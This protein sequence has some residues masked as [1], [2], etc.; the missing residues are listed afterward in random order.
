M[1]HASLLFA[2]LKENREATMRAARECL[3]MSVA[4][5]LSQ[6]V[7][8]EEDM[9]QMHDGFLALVQEALEERPPETRTLYLDVVLPSLLASGNSVE[10]LAFTA[11]AW[12]I[13][14][15]DIVGPKLPAEA[16]DEC[17]KWI[18]SFFAKLVVDI[19]RVRPAPRSVP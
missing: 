10:A 1:Q 17:V 2:V 4:A 19:S 11:I 15:T 14:L 12:S 3:P 8:G 5:G 16:H 7:Y 6:P 18:S 9:M 13:L